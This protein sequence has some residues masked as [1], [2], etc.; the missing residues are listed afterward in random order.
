VL[1]TKIKSLKM[2]INKRS[3]ERKEEFISRCIAVE[4]E[5]GYDDK[6]AAA[7]CY[8][9]WTS[10]N[11]KEIRKIRRGQFKNLNFK[12]FYGNTRTRNNPAGLK[13]SNIWKWKWNSE[14]EELVIKFQEGDTWTYS[15]VNESLFKD[16]TE[17]NASCLTSGSNRFGEWQVGKTPSI[18]A[19][20]W[21]YLVSAG[22]SESKGG[23]V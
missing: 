15:G 1:K 5:A 22:V 17:G 4:K 6:Q 20:V 16:V 2:P 21:K 18:G 13:S 7:I 14:T 19:A 8:S 3:G 12:I 11:M 9:Y 10:E 23:Q